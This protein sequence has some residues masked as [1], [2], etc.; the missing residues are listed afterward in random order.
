MNDSG[1][2]NT[3]IYLNSGLREPCPL[4]QL[5][6]GL[7]VGIVGLLELLLQQ[8]QLLSLER[9]STASKLWTLVVGAV[10]LAV[11]SGRLRS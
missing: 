3:I 5:I 9:R 2:G 10:R 1:L 6:P 4:G 8:L 7:E 11:F